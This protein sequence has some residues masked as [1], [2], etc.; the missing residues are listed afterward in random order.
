[1]E[2]LTRRTSMEMHCVCVCVRACVRAC[3]R[4]YKCIVGVLPGCALL[5]DFPGT[6][7]PGRVRMAG[8]LPV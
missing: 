8:R 3:V 2:Q 6:G 7:V 5:A 4:V 1:V